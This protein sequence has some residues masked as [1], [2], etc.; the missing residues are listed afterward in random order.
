MQQPIVSL[1]L[2]R[3]IFFFVLFSIVIF[4]LYLFFFQLGKAPLDN[5]DEAW[6]AEMIKEMIKTKDFIVPHWNRAVFLDRLPF[7]LWTGVFFT[8]F[9]GISE[10]SI[11]LTSAVSGFILTILIFIYL[12]KKYGFLPAMMGYASLALNNLFIWRS[13]S[14]NFDTL[15]TFFTFLSYLVL[16]NNSKIRLPLLGLLFSLIYLTRGSYVLFPLSI[17]FIHDLIFCWK[18]IYK[19]RLAYI[20]C[21]AIFIGIISIWLGLGY[22]KEGVAFLQFYLFHS[23]HGVATIHL[24][25]FNLD[26]IKYAYYSLQ[27]YYFYFFIFGLFLLLRHI[28]NPEYFLQLVFSIGLLILLSFAEKRNNWYLLPAMPF[29]SLTIAYATYKILQFFKNNRV[30]LLLIGLFVTYFSYKTF[31]I[32][33]QPIIYTTSAIDEA[34]SAKYIKSHLTKDEVIIRLDHQFPTF[35]YYSDK[36]VLVSSSDSLKSNYWV[37]IDRATTARLVKK[38]KV[39][40]LAGEGR[41]VAYFKQQ[42][43]ELQFKTIKINANETILQAL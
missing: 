28:K 10:L 33:I 17:F 25:S 18:E 27:R 31:F 29:W 8:L 26:Y 12:Y 38:G 14:G 6:H 40:W 9:F 23:D 36:K 22:L 5:W 1:L 41:D 39:H 21:F 34:T 7:N 32:N 11:R 20:A 43:P 42:Y 2:R 24:H 35:V 3:N 16:V 37:Y 4:G 30:A 13:R 19:N 15:T